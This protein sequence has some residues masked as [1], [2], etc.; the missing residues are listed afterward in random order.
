MHKQKLGLLTCAALLATSLIACGTPS[1]TP[2]TETS[3][4]TSGPEGDGDGDPAGDGDGD[5]G[6]TD[7]PT[8]TPG[9]LGCE[10]DN[11]MCAE[12]LACEN[13]ECGFPTGDG[14]GDGDGDLG[15]CNPD[16]PYC[17]AIN[18]CMEAGGQGLVLD[19]DQNGSPDWAWCLYDCFNPGNGGDGDGDG[20]GGDGD[21]D[22][23]TTETGDGDGGGTTG[24]GDGDGTTTGT[25]GDG[26]GDTTGDGDG[27]ATGDGD[28]DM[29]GP[30]DSLCP[31]H[32]AGG[33][34]VCVDF[35]QMGD[36]GCFLL[37]S[38]NDPNS[39]A[40]GSMCLGVG[41]GTNICVYLPTGF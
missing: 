10:C 28:G 22:G 35:S 1:E 16:D 25:T 12:G 29:P 8:C 36:Y 41:G 21:G 32:P 7:G 17:P 4:S 2:D 24:D 6:T 27:D 37:C 9:D 33:Q 5:P 23:G 18:G 11:G 34:A 20:D 13:N 26:D 30:D 14:D 3:T 40:P 19:T 38:P 39:C 15:D 31:D